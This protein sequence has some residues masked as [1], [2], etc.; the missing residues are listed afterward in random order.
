MVVC[1]CE[2]V[3]EESKEG[4]QDGKGSSFPSLRD[5]PNQCFT[6]ETI[7]DNSGIIVME[8]PNKSAAMQLLHSAI[9]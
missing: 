7:G 4:H 6:T 8:L 9:L 5:S 2:E 3:F 1:V